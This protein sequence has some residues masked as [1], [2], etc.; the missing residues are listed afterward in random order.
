MLQLASTETALKVDLDFNREMKVGGLASL[1]NALLIGA[2]AYGQ[3][4]FNVLNYGFT[5]QTDNPLAAIVCGLFCGTLF[6]LGEP[7]INIL[8]RFLLSGLLVFSGA[9]FLIENLWDARKK[10]GRYEFACIWAVFLINM[11]AGELMP[12]F[13]LLLAI[14]AGFL[15]CLIGFTYRFTATCTIA[16]P[17]SGY[18]YSSTAV[19][20][21]SQEMKLGVLG[22]WYHIFPCS[23][24]L[25][26]GTSATLYN[27]FKQ[28]VADV[29]LMPRPKRTKYIVFDM[30]EVYEVGSFE[31]S[32]LI[33]P[34]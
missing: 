4:K 3:T 32:L 30:T 31:P 25:F 13:G 26:F 17:I 23:G 1:V 5:H 8:P 24:Y 10:F 20:S 34:C 15:L 21:F 16:A 14:G 11:V 2:P 19:R 7:V 29:S 18:D 33:T 22:C 12:Q 6:F 27:Q 9:G 28:H